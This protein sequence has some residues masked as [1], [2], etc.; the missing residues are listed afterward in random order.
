MSLKLSVIQSLAKG[1][2]TETEK[3]KEKK[4]KSKEGDT[5]GNIPPRQSWERVLAT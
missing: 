5:S 1:T 2:W 4:K 3:N